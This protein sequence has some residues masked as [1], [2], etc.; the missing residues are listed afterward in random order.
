MDFSAA[1]GESDRVPS[2][3]KEIRLNWSAV[4]GGLRPDCPLIRKIQKI[5]EPT[6]G[7]EPLTC[8]LRAV[9]SIFK[10]FGDG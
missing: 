7:L 4:I 8:R 1:A 2:A 3:C 9:T 6:S 5:L 10:Y